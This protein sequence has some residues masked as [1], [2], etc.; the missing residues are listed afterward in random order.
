M[1]TIS[2]RAGNQSI[3]IKVRRPSWDKVYE[4]Y[5]KTSDERDDMPAYDVFNSIFSENNI[6]YF[7]DKKTQTVANA[8]ATRLSLG[9]LNGNV[10]LPVAY[11]LDKGEFKGK[12]IITSA[13]GMIAFLNKIFGHPDETINQPGNLEKVQKVI[14][15]RKGIYAMLPIA[16]HF[17][18]ASGH[19]T[20]W[21][22]K[23]VIGS[24]HYAENA[25]V[26]Y[27]W[28]LK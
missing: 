16:G 10:K 27:F 17:S 9:L 11:R 1:S 2:A 3:S 13:T 26:V 15:N 14:G 6:H 23:D 21:T 12:G 8:C 28:E 5:P 20:L 7:F 25:K 19:V 18:T 22:G 24:H 4:G